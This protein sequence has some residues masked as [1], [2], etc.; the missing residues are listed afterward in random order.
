AGSLNPT[1]TINN[2]ETTHSYSLTNLTPETDYN[3]YVR[4]KCADDDFSDWV[5][6]TLT[7]PALCP[8]PANIV[9]S[10]LTETSATITWNGYH[11]T[12]WDFVYSATQL[13]DPATGNM[14]TVDAATYNIAGLSIATVYYVYVRANC[15]VD[16]FS[17]WTDYSFRTPCGDVTSFPWTE[18]LE[19]GVDCWTMVDADGDGYGW[20]AG[21]ATDGIYLDG[22][23]LTGSG[24]N[25][26]ADMLVSGSYSNVSY[27][28]L[29]PDNWAI[30]PAL[31]LT[32]MDENE[33]LKLTY[34][35]K[36]SDA[37]YSEE[38]YKV[39][40]STTTSAISSFTTTLIDEI[41]EEG[42]NEWQER[43]IDLSSYSGQR[44]YLAFVHYDVTDQFLILIDDI[45][46]A[47]PSGENDIITFSVPDMLTVDIDNTN[48]RVAAEISNSSTQDLSAIV[49]TITVSD[50][51]EITLVNG[52]DYTEGVAQD[53]TSPV[54]YTVKAEN[55][56]TQDWTVTVA[57]AAA[58]SSEKDILAFSFAGQVGES[59]IDPT[60]HS[61][62]AVARWNM[63]LNE[64]ISPTIEISPL[65]T[66]SPASGAAQTFAEPVVYT[67]TAEDATTQDWT[68]TIS[69]A[70]LDVA[71]IPFECDFED[72][73]ENGNWVFEN[74]GQT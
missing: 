40:V 46:V 17:A 61:I 20:V 71:G 10:A 9:A 66:I 28:A 27:E 47:Q 67:V 57:R 50:Y 26:S 23:N 64:P 73:S 14:V 60:A 54:V 48:H 21:S 42:N 51:A 39:C 16:E 56:S 74:D 69:L 45:T 49:P 36:A 30:S 19:N 55:N 68:V 11:A 65:A 41:L 15:G 12:A 24:H 8:V 5:P 2:V 32:Q 33:P 59:V 3:V 52:T 1:G 7:T 6:F 22:G 72:V 62:T 70:Q 31:D 29:T 37:S 43:N 63:N 34:F 58:P 18:D 38:H 25:S 35:V 13:A 44:I 53:F 4:A